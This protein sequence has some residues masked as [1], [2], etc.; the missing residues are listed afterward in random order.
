MQATT[1]NAEQQQQRQQ[2][3]DS[4][5]KKSLVAPMS[6]FPLSAVFIAV[7]LTVV[8]ISDAAIADQGKVRFATFNAAL[9]RPGRGELAGELEAPSSRQAMRIAEIIQRVRPDVLL[10]NEF[11][12]DADGVFDH[13]AEHLNLGT[14][15]AVVAGSNSIDV[16]VPAGALPGGSVARL[17]LSTHG[18]LSPTR[19]AGN[20]EVEDHS[21]AIDSLDFAARAGCSAASTD[22]A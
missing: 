13:P 17:R 18:E 22:Y 6:S 1:E 14:S 9:N 3:Q 11:D 15:I 19:L 8:A 20:G 5:T 21:V 4:K 7:L 10:I 12:F 16:N 2:Q